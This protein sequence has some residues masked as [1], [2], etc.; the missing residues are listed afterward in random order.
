MEGIPNAPTIAGLDR[1]PDARPLIG[2]EQRTARLCLSTLGV[3]SAGSMIGVAS[4]LYLVTEYPLLL[5]ALSPLG[6][7]LILVAPVVDPVAFVAV[8]VGRR[9][10]FYQACFHLGRALGPAGITWIET[11]AARF[12]H[13]V[14][15][16]ERLFARASH[17]VVLAMT[18]PTVSAL[19]GISG[20][21]TAVFTLL[22]T[23]G[24]VARMLVLLYF[25]EWLR[26]PIESV[27]ALIHEYWIPGTV[28]IVVIVAIHRW[29]QRTA[30]PSA[31]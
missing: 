19:A 5:I 29:R 21:R 31:G 22:A 2:L 28:V 23:L 3:L 10:L 26:G 1:P 17:T 9:L 11:R 27:R 18:G 15:W 12:A 14:R 7:H 8:A 13:F 24:L 20:M 4:S 6:R 30:S 25:A 16:L